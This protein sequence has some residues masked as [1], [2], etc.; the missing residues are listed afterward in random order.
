MTSDPRP[1]SDEFPPVYAELDQ[2]DHYRFTVRF[3]GT[4]LEPRVVDESPPIGAGAGPDPVLQLATTIGHCMSSTLVNTMERSRI[5]ITPVRTRV[6]VHLGR[7][8][9][10][11]KRVTSMEVQI[12]CAPLDEADRARF[13]HGV[14]IFEDY[15]TVSGSVREGVRIGTR[16]GPGPVPAG[17]SAPPP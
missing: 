1:A 11:R 9:R 7:N 13:D 14:E 5:R 15:C 6:T 17:P 12:E 8:A 4:P 3:P 16:V 2:V 10:G